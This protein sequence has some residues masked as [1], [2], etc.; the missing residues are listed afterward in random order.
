MLLNGAP[1]NV[2]ALAVK[3]GDL[4]V[5]M[6]VDSPNGK[7]GEDLKTI[8]YSLQFEPGKD[9]PVK[10]PP[11]IQEFLDK[12]CSDIV[13]H[14]VTKVVTHYSDRFLNS[15]NRKGGMEQFWRGLI[16]PI[17]SFEVAITDLVPAGARAYLTGFTISN[18]FGKWPITETSILKESGEWK[19][20]GNQRDVA[21]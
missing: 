15:G 9:E 7:I 14:D 5:N 20:F 1:Y 10:V 12:W 16:G 13:S 18:V 17:T 11:D 4:W 19:W 21:P 2:M 3:K 8:L 6:G